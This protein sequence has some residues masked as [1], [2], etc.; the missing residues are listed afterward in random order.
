MSKQYPYR[1]SA[2]QEPGRVAHHPVV[3]VGAGPSGLTAA[4]ELGVG[5]LDVVVLDD[6]NTV[7]SG[8]RAICFA[9][10]T[11]EIWDRLECAR[12]ML[13]KG[14]VWQLGRVFHRDAQVY[15]FNLM[16]EGGYKMPAFINLQQY[17][18]ETFLID[19]VATV[20]AIE[21]RWKNRVAR[22]TPRAD[23]VELDIETP[24]GGY[25]LTCD[26]LIAADGANSSI[27]TS[28]G[29]T[30]R[31]QTFQDQFL[32][33][34]IS[35]RADFPTERW[36]WFDPPFNPGRS[37]LL[38]RQP[39]NVWRIDFQIGADADPVAAL[40]IENIA[41]RIDAMLGENRKWKLEWA[42]AYTFRCLKLDRFVHGRV[43]FVGDAAHQVS[44]FGARGAN[45]A[46]Q[47]VDNLAWKLVRVLRGDAPA[48]LL[49]SYDTERQA[50]AAENLLNSTRATDFITPK[51][52][53]SRVFRDS[54][55]CLAKHYPFAR[56]LVNSGR[57]SV[58]CCYDASPLNTPDCEP[59]TP[60]ASPG[61]ACP[62]ASV[63]V[64]GCEGW[65]LDAFGDTFTLLTAGV[66]VP[67]GVRNVPDLTLLEVGTD[68]L[69]TNGD[70]A[71]RYDLVQGG[72]YLIRPDQCVAARWRRVDAD[73]VT[74]A[75]KRAL[76]FE[77]EVAA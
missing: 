15:Q 50:G 74:H 22:V 56:A 66:D 2:D 24:D 63:T 38:H 70:L 41:P 30:V 76:G 20:P 47:G 73:A 10:R 6:N 48:A 8:S 46:V 65:L 16:R 37:V 25:T 3:V 21:L 57:L 43:L 61:S 14:V 13:E 18:V 60:L 68:L 64:N 49:S 44:P 26:Y 32:I 69:D 31:G 67:E 52:E 12:P 34:D 28:L 39:D 17:Y 59:F 75:M 7:S 53:I 19:R 35:M 11:L 4:I 5:G 62:D 51:S 23:L 58:P 42:S 54:V 27:R 77:L 36:F 1:R 29:A 45:G 71:R 40:R 55:L 9:K 33:C 72:A